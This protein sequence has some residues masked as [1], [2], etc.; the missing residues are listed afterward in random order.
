MFGHAFSLDQ[1]LTRVPFVATGPDAPVIERTASLLELPR[2]LAEAAG[3]SRHPWSDAVLEGGIAVSQI[4]PPVDVDDPRID[5]AVATLGLDEAAVELLLARQT[6]VTDGRWKLVAFD[7]EARS[8]DLAKDPGE[9]TALDPSEAPAALHAALERA[10]LPQLTLD[11]DT[12]RR[13]AGRRARG[14]HALARLPLIADTSRSRRYDR[15]WR[16]SPIVER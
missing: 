16:A 4:D 15:T 1:R 11:V 5:E 8:H 14:P 13:A 2:L 6:A 9:R 7:D 12:P 10:S 3:L